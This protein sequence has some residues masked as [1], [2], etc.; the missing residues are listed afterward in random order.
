MMHS[1]LT[2]R[3]FLSIAVGGGAVSLV[4][5]CQ[6]AAPPASTS[7]TAAAAAAPTAVSKPANQ[8]G[9][10]VV[11]ANSLYQS[12]IVGGSF[13]GWAGHIF[14]DACYERLYNFRNHTQPYPNLATGYKVSTDG[15]TYTFDL[16]Q[17]VKFHDGSPFNADA[18]VFNYMRYLDKS[19]PYYDPQAVTAL[20]FLSLVNTITAKDDHTVEFVLKQPRRDFVGN[21]TAMF[22]GIVSPTAVQKY[23][24]TDI[25]QHPTGTGPFMFDKQENNQLTMV[26]NPDYWGGRPPLDK[27]IVRA[28]P[29]SQAMTASLL[30]GE[31][32]G[33]CWPDLNNLDTF[34]NNPNL[35]VVISPAANASY[36]GVNVEWPALQDVRARQAMAHSIN[37]QK[38]MDTVYHGN[39]QPHKGGQCDAPIWWFFSSDLEDYY[40]YDVAKAKSL[41]DQAGGPRDLPIWVQTSEYWPL[42]GELLQN[43][44]NAAGFNAQVVKVDPATYFSGINEGKHG[45]YM[46]EMTAA[47]AGAEGHIY[48]HWGCGT[49]AINNIGH[50]CD[51]QWDALR[52]K[53]TSDPLYNDQDKRKDVMIQLEKGLL[54]AV[55]GLWH[56]YGNITTVLNKRVQGYV[57]GTHP[58]MFIDQ[59][60]ITQ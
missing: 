44:F 19:H 30:S 5:A 9:T 13:Q 59:T 35:N 10:L 50:W 6:G 47:A 43:D 56:S 53:E 22:C 33:T 45:V 25:G 2:R 52:E 4:A 36:M 12:Y 3:R 60:Y 11:A 24:V 51:P 29:D 17:G 28:I 48:A 16:R 57:P 34:R 40:T 38:I 20:T 32:D 46:Y 14:L 26:A 39:V 58:V 18:V 54:D 55:V 37:K 31:V 8:G 21:L 1:G 27:V 15:L 49:A 41:L 23:G 42:L 7:P